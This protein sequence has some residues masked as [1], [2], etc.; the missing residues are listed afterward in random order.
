MAIND[1]GTQTRDIIKMVWDRIVTFTPNLVGAL[2]IVLVGAIVGVILGYVVT[3]ILQAVRLQSLSDQSKFSD[4]L[5]KAK[6][7]TDIA[8]IT[9]SF[10]K[11]VVILA[12]FIPAANILQVTGVQ[13]FFEGIFAFIPRVLGVGLLVIFG[14]LVANLFAALGRAATDSY[15][16][17]LSKLVE[18]LIRWAFY[19]S[20]ATTSLFALGVPTEFTV[21]IFIGLVST[22]ALGFGL[23]FG[24][25]AQGHMNDLV[26]SARDEFKQ[27]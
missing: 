15:G 2:L 1:W 21:I 12:F 10:V 17:T 4:V 9:G 8:E 18:N 25:G 19:V 5:K 16:L 24:L 3:K 23:A 11:W 7:N 6:L 14:Y 27:K 13:N 22:I 26:K 20:I